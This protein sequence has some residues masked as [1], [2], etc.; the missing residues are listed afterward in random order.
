MTTIKGD[1]E[2]ID[3]FQLVSMLPV[4]AIVIPSIYLIRARMFSKINDVDKTMQELEDE[5]KIGPP[6]NFMGRLKDYF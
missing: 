1:T 4:M 6:K 2:Y 3:E 5:F